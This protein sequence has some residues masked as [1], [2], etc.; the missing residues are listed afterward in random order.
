MCVNV[1]LKCLDDVLQK[2]LE[3]SEAV[4]PA[5]SKQEYIAHCES[6]GVAVRIVQNPHQSDTVVLVFDTESSAFPL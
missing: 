2:I 4:V 5:D 6:Y 3:C 1:S